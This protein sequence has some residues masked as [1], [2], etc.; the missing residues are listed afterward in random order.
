[1]KELY[2]LRTP[3]EAEPTRVQSLTTQ[4]AR[5]QSVVFF[6]LLII[7]LAFFLYLWTT[8]RVR[9]NV[10][11]G[12]VEL[13]R[14][15]NPEG[16]QNLLSV[17]GSTELAPFI[18]YKLANIYF[19]TGKYPQ[20]QQEYE[21]IRDHY[22]DH[23]VKEWTERCLK[24]LLITTQWEPDGELNKRLAELR[25]KR[26]LPS[27]I[28]KTAK[29]TFEIDLLEDDAPNTVAHFIS[30]VDEQFYH[31][32]VFGTWLDLKPASSA[33]IDVSGKDEKMGLCLE[34]RHISSTITTTLSYTIPFE[35]TSLE[36][37]EGTVG[38]LRKID[39]DSETGRPEQDQ[40]LNSADW[41]FYILVKKNPELD[42]KYTVFGQVTK[43]MDV[44][45]NLQ[46]GDMIEEMVVNQK[47]QHEYHPTRLTG[48]T[49]ESK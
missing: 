7:S 41:R 17:H 30:L 22:P 35:V 47:R 18:H 16:L 24:E 15:S 21:Y 3:A 29:G 1:M 39:P 36:H 26:N 12:R 4:L 11:T 28:V 43:G 44:V 45:Q 40:F 2:K 9:Q 13:E 49:Q 33:N 10:K 14:V 34:G 6:I 31:Q 32:T 37:R 46:P 48:T 27:V 25:E 8:Y 20:A 23:P 42:G 38:M 5:Y 19:D